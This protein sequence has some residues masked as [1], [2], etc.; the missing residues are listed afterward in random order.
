MEALMEQTLFTVSF[1]LASMLFGAMLFFSFFVAP[2]T[3]MKLE[4]AAAGQFIRSIFP[5]YYL[6]I[7]ITSL[8]AAVLL[9]IANHSASILMFIIGL[10]GVFSRQSLIPKINKY[11]DAEIAGDLIAKSKFDRL[12][13]LSV[14]INGAQLILLII[15]IVTLSGWI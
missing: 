9:T 13:R 2:I 8:V 6:I 5:H 15:S 7:I 11:R 3:F 10:S 12:H 1:L 14:V 4:A